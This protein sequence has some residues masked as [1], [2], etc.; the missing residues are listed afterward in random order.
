MCCEYKGVYLSAGQR[1]CS[2]L[3][4]CGGMVIAS[5]D[6][7]TLHAWNTDNGEDMI[8]IMV[9][10]LIFSVSSLILSCRKVAPYFF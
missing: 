8:I 7:G 9:L 3:A 1:C 4:P 2:L 10:S 6:Q 5:G